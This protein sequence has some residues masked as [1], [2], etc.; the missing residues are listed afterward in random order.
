MKECGRDHDDEAGGRSCAA[1]SRPLRQVNAAVPRCRG[2]Q[3][4]GFALTQ[5]CNLR[6]T[7]CIR[8]D[9]DARGRLVTCCQLFDY[10]HNTAEVVTDLNVTGVASAVQTYR[11]RL[12]ELVENTE[13]QP[14]DADPFNRFP[15]TRCAR[16]YGKL[17]WL[18]LY[19]DSPW[20]GAAG[21]ASTSRPPAGAGSGH[22]AG[23]S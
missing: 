14:H 5:H 10:G 4:L 9:I 6:C 8:D 19:P 15:C 7:H 22:A 18:R 1:R 12:A 17:E 2:F 11:R 20:R 16:S 13:P 3:F 21:P 23:L